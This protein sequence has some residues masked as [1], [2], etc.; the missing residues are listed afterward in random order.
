MLP[1]S[2]INDSP[3]QARFQAGQAKRMVRKWNAA[4]PAGTAVLFWNR[5]GDPPI[6]TRTRSQ[7]WVADCGVPVVSVD[8][9]SGVADGPV[10]LFHV[11]PT[12]LRPP[13]VM[14]ADLSPPAAWLD[15]P[16]VAEAACDV[17][18]EE[19]AA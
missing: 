12:D 3:A 7:A 9:I 10:S 15:P 13:D 5:F 18:T 14:L 2:T 16:I 17:Q 4:W 1:E 8:R 6:E 19:E 11:L